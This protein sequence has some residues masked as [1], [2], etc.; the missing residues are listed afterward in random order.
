ME[1]TFIFCGL[2]I[3]LTF[4][5][6]KIWSSINL[7]SKQRHPVILYSHVS[8]FGASLTVYVINRIIIEVESFVTYKSDI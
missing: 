2:S 6:Y 5:T 4:Y 3:P 8:L 7:Q 1:N